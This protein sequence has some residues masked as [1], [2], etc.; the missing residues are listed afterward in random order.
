MFL[1]NGTTLE[2]IAAQLPGARGKDKITLLSQLTKA[3][4]KENPK[5]AL[6]YG[7]Q[8]LELLGN[9]P[10]KKL[11]AALMTHMSHAYRFIGDQETAEEYARNSLAAARQINDKS[12]AAA[13]LRS[14]GQVSVMTGKLDSARDYFFKSSQL[15]KELNDQA[16]LALS[17][18]CIAGVHYDKGEYVT[19]LKYLFKALKIY[20]GLNHQ[21]GIGSMNVNI[22]VIYWELKNFDKSLAYSLES[23]K[24]LEGLDDK[25]SLVLNLNNIGRIYSLKRRYDKCMYYLKKAMKISKELGNKW[26]ISAVLNSVG[27]TFKELENDRLALEYFNRALDIREELNDKVGIADISI[28][29][30][31]VY[32]RLGRYKEAIQHA[33]KGLEIARQTHVKAE[34]S[35]AC[36]VLSAVYEAAGDLEKAL[37]YYKKYKKVNDTIFNENTTKRITDL[38]T[39]F[40]IERRQREIE[41]LRKDRENQKNIRN[42][43]ILFA[44]L[45]LLV[46]FVIFARFR[47][48]A[49]ATRALAKE[50]E[51]RK[52]TEQK[53]GESEK[54]FRVLAEKS[55]VGIRIIQDHVIKYANPTATNIF[56]YPLE[57]MIDKSPLE[58][59]IEED[60]PL[61]SQHLKQ[62]MARTGDILPYEFKGIT[63]N[64]EI[65]HLESYGSLIL[66][67][68]RPAV[69]ESVIDITRRKKT[70]A[71]LI[72][73]R[74]MESVGIL[75]GGIAHDFNNLLAVIVGNTSMLKLSLGNRG[76]RIS[77]LLGK[78]EQ[79]SARAAE[80]AQKFITF[81]NGGWGIRKKVK[82]SDILKNNHHF[83]PGVGD[84]LCDISI[85]PD[86][87]PIY[88]DERH[89]RQV[90]TNLLLNAHEANSGNNEKIIIK[91]Q[92][93]TLEEENQFA[94]K[95]GEYVKVLVID[96]GRGIPP[97]LLEKI[98]DPYF[99]TKDT[100]SK[101]GLGMGLA[102]CYSIVKKHDG[103]IAISSKPQK[104]TTVEI[105]LPVYNE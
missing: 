23:L 67:Q 82:F 53:L 85:P 21:W 69:L 71:E 63:K 33:H 46:A 26:L 15:Y 31:S 75:V 103:H 66:Y 61:V 44:C 2:K 68:A 70:E 8:A 65:L 16:N 72:K 32:Q 24:I 5:Q 84:I 60:R 52:F 64:G 10:D 55:V 91:A 17:F 101:K 45:I 48:K 96:K 99:S 81:S 76:P 92:N 54:K 13:A 27:Y 14:L 88:A 29:I 49:R 104:G 28:N 30:A 39:H 100:V 9:F 57:E 50:I 3:Y 43:L 87:A 73:S 51:A 35:D 37:D 79:A 36:Q 94:L 18:N 42:F 97:Q 78:V 59:V 62:R 7:K 102:I 41:L 20:E 22:G 80:L 95:N 47:L 40:E 105:Y 83:S 12:G 4:L 90:M 34:I 1:V 77:A 56:G 11:R 25:M 6:E 98:F 19:T 58:L 89:L 74:K 93:I 86:L 38:Q